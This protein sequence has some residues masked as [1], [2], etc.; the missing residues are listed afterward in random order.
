MSDAVLTAED[1]RHPLWHKIKRHLE[2]EIDRLRAKNDDGD[3][4]MDHDETLALRAEIRAV[5]KL[6]RLGEIQVAEDESHY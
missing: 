5:K 1:L 4:K 6:L 2:G 3:G